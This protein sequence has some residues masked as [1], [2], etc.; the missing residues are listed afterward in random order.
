MPIIPALKRE[1]D[2]YKFSASPASMGYLVSS[3]HLVLLGEKRE[4]DRLTFLKINR[5][6][7]KRMCFN[8][9][10]FELGV[11][12]CMSLTPALKFRGSL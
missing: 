1:E 12:A 9:C 10:C 2:S 7:C 4:T 6:D 3:V 11:G 8:T 5:E